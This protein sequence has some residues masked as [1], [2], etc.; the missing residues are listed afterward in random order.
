MGASGVLTQCD[1]EQ[2]P[3][4]VYSEAGFIV[5]RGAYS[6]ESM[7]GIAA[8]APLSAKRDNKIKIFMH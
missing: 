2:N 4:P 7:R 3:M 6:Q 8:D 5:F 1:N